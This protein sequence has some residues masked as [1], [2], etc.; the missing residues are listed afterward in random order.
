MEQEI[1]TDKKNN[2]R[3]R[4]KERETS[5]N[6]WESKERKKIA[7]K[8]TEKGI[9]EETLENKEDKEDSETEYIQCEVLSLPFC[10]NALKYLP[11]LVF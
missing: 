8:T 11:C 7:E 6:D 4:K 5:I 9:W 2:Q 10:T 1:N 3:E